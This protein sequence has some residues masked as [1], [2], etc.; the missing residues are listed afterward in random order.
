[1]VTTLDGARFADV[2]RAGALAVVRERETLDR[3]NVFPVPDADTGANLAATLRAAAAQLGDEGAAR[4][5]RRG[6]RRRRRGA[7]RRAR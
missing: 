4:H 3:I 2:V 5:R 1:M 7:R 6:P